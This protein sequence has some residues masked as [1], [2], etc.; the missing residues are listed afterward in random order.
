MFAPGRFLQ[1]V[2][3]TA[4][5]AHRRGEPLFRSQRVGQPAS[6]RSLPW[7]NVKVMTLTRWCPVRC[8]RNTFHLTPPPFFCFK[9]STARAPRVARAA[10]V[11]GVARVYT[12]QGGVHCVPTAGAHVHQHHG[13]HGN[14]RIPRN[15][16]R[17][18]AEGETASHS[19]RRGVA[20]PG[21][22]SRCV[23]TRC[24]WTL[25]AGPVDAGSGRGTMRPDRG[26]SG[27]G[28]NTSK[29]A[30]RALG[31]EQRGRHACGERGMHT[32]QDA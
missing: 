10:R 4:G 5:E 2:A 26:L 3:R 1:Y 32:K 31:R 30:L 22:A 17:G 27:L 14:A 19:V 7:D 11:R 12:L 6:V 24:P 20:S 18:I 9:N 8:K 29:N 25:D 13:P 16:M 15:Y 21:P 23:C 28:G